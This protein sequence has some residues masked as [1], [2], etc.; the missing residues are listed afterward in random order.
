MRKVI[1]N[2]NMLVEFKNFSADRLDVDGLVALLAF[3]KVLRAE[4]ETQ[5][6]EVPEYVG[7]Q[8]RSL[9]REIDAKVADKREAERKRLK[10]QLEALKTPSE[11]KTEIAARL[12]VLEKEIAG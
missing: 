6:L 2:K 9:K 1:G 7:V 5:K 8:I 10:A 12:E 4:F 3:G 11:R